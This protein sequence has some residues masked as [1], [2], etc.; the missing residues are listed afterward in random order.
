[1]ILLTN[2]ASLDGRYFWTRTN[3]SRGE[4]PVF[5]DREWGEGLCND[6]KD[7]ELIGELWKGH[8]DLIVSLV[9][10]GCFLSINLYWSLTPILPWSWV[11]AGA[12]YWPDS[13]NSCSTLQLWR[14]EPMNDLKYWKYL[15]FVQRRHYIRSAHS[16][17]HI[18]TKTKTAF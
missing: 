3:N 7:P 9:W 11:D 16:M 5:K 8:R 12:E 15:N 10:L 18:Q 13:F 14:L 2:D 17:I 4:L 1:M 6:S